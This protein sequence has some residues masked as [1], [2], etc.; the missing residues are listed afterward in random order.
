MHLYGS[1]IHERYCAIHRHNTAVPQAEIALCPGMGVFVHVEEEMRVQND[2]R[3]LVQLYPG[4]P[5][6]ENELIFIPLNL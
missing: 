2:F 1:V 5:V 4:I 3:V 6:G